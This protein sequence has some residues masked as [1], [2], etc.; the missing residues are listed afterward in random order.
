MSIYR[1]KYNTYI[2]QI[3]FYNLL[4][5]IKL[6]IFH[7]FIDI[8]YRNLLVSFLNIL[9]SISIFTLINWVFKSKKKEIFLG[10]YMALSL[11]MFFDSLYFSHFFTLIPINAIYQI[12]HLSAVSGSVKTLIKPVYFL[13]FL[14][15]PILI[16]MYSRN[17]KEEF[18]IRRNGRHKQLALVLLL[19]MC[20]FIGNQQIKAAAGGFYTPFNMGIYNYH[21]YDI[22]QLFGKTSPFIENADAWMEK[23]ED[24]SSTNI[25]LK[26]HGLLKGKNLIVIQAES[27]QSFVLN[28]EIDGQY[29]T[30][31]LNALI[32]NDSMYFSR[33]YEQVGWGNTSDAEFVTHNGLHAS[34]INFSYKQYEGKQLFSLPMVL[35]ELGYETTVFHGNSPEFWNRKNMYPTIGFNNFISSEELNMDEIIGI[36]L[37]DKSFFKQAIEH[38]KELP[39]PFYSFF[40]TLTS[41]YPYVMEEE[42][43]ELKVEG[44][45]RD[46]LLGDYLQTVNY[47]DSAIGELIDQLKQEGLYDNTAIVIYGDHHGLDA[48]NEIVF[49]QMTDFLGK[50][51]QEDEMYRVPMIVHIP[52][53]NLK[54]EIKTVGGQ[55]DFYPTISNL[56]GLDH[57]ESTLIGKDLLNTKEGFAVQ[58][59]HTGKGSFIDN[60]KIFI[61]SKDG[62]FE[63]SR[64]WNIQTGEPVVLEEARKGYERAIAEIFLSEYIIEN[65]FPELSESNTNSDQYDNLR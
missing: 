28:K 2:Y 54:K 63:N 51:Y 44:A 26:Y 36:G 6:L 48:R 65:V 14:D 22:Y 57:N 1:K 24:G 9:T 40:I 60:D 59:V 18:S 49:E 3:A 4:I 35:S 43:K 56:I 27:L 11:L 47:L 21:I 30:P 42:Y 39:T 58:Q 15:W 45:L 33:Y 19:F 50:P 62:I 52:Q 55:I 32:S 38:L 64:A 13:Y 23:L 8:Q 34:T 20:I 46:T 10:L 12:G 31:V 29:I 17:K 16:Y 5:F 41:H 61:I 25:E 53:S 7:S 37:S